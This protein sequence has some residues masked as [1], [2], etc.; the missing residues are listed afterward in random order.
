[1]NRRKFLA[2]LVA[3]V[4]SALALRLPALPEPICVVP[5]PK[6]EP[7][8]FWQVTRYDASATLTAKMLEDMVEHLKHQSMQPTIWI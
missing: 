1:M 7:A 4:V 3:G 8:D 5:E 2:S 6:V